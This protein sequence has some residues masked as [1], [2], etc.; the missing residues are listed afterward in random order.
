MYLR[1]E[2]LLSSVGVE[3]PI[4]KQKP[5]IFCLK[6]MKVKDAQWQDQTNSLHGNLTMLLSKCKY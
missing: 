6:K 1:D 3:P 2:N 4:I 5:N